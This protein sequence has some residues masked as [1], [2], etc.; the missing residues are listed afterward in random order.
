MVISLSYMR[1]LILLSAMCAASLV[2]A[3]GQTPAPQYRAEMIR[4]MKG[5]GIDERGFANLDVQLY[6]GMT[7]DVVK[8]V[9]GQVTLD[10]D[11]RKVVVSSNEV[12]LSEKTASSA[13]LPASGAPVPASGSTPV[14][15]VMHPGFVP[16]GKLV[17]LSAHYTLSGNQPRNVKTK[18]EKML[19][20]GPLKA[21]V[22][23]LVSDELSRAAQNEPKVVRQDAA[24]ITED[25]ILVESQTRVNG[26]NILTVE[27]IYNNQR[28]TK[29]A[30]EGTRMVLP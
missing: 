18:V 23:I 15:V 26:P 29:Q 2:T 3:F 4:T 22:E 9:I 30:F 1:L 24:I 12:V 13:P 28:L 11:G 8:R 10:V 6:K 5:R 27:Y 17:V 25:V 20:P 16:G 14:V 7:Y 21:P 19:P